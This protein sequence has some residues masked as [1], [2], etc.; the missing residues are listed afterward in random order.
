MTFSLEMYK[1][2]LDT[3]VLNDTILRM[4]NTLEANGDNYTDTFPI[5]INPYEYTFASE[6]RKTKWLESYKL[7]A[8]TT[9][10]EAF[11]YFKDR[12]DIENEDISEI[13]KILVIR[14]R[15]SSE[16]Y[17]STKSLTIS[18]N[19]SRKS[20]LIFAEQSDLYP[21][22]TVGQ[23]SKRKYPNES[24]A[25]HILGYIGAISQKQYDANKDK[26]Y[27]MS[28]IYGQTGVEYVFESYLKGKNGTKQI[29]MSVDGGIVSEIHQ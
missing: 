24:L 25:S 18:N 28:D 16:G 13:R 1:T 2:K 19:V 7:D 29:D 11:N 9:A 20:A 15:I 10:E 8:N 26:G 3:K 27:L 6:Q 12:Y 21:G 4:V 22:I 14:Y 17:S 23:S 5:K